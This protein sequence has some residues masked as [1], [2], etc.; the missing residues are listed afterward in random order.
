MNNWYRELRTAFIIVAIT[1]VITLVVSFSLGDGPMTWAW[2]WENLLYNLYYGI[3]MTLGNGWLFDYIGRRYPWDKQPRKRAWIGIIGSIIFTMALLTGLNFILWYFVFGNEVSMLWLWRNRTFLI[4]ALIITAILTITLHAIGFFQEV[5]RERILNARLRQDKLEMELGALRSQV[6]P[7]FLFNSF[8]VLSGL[9]DE[10]PDKAQVFLARL[11]SIYRY[12][13][14]QRNE[15]TS[16][17]AEELNFAQQYL[18]LQQTRFEDSIQLDTQISKEGLVKKIPSLSLQLLLENAVKHNG[19]NPTNPLQIK[20]REEQGQLV[21]Q[22]SRKA[23]RSLAKSSGMGLQNIK[24]R[25]KL[26]SEQE[27]EVRSDTLSFTVKLPL[28]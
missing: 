25:Y 11:S 23:R 12:V 21:V 10:D 18:S 28:L 8:N 24:D 2:A 20:I 1:Y 19:F 3:P 16:T 6:D 13:L 17:V 5:Q 27:P 14:E 7:H 4:V 26:L 15:T 22:N 9:I